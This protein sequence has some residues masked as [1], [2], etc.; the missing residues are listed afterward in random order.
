MPWQDEEISGP[1]GGDIPE[2]DALAGVFCFIPRFDCSV[3]GRFDIEDGNGEYA[4]SSIMHQARFRFWAAR[5]VNRDDDWPLK[6]F[7]G[8]DSDERDRLLFCIRTSL[9]L[10]DLFLPIGTHVS[11]ESAQPAHI[12][13]A[14]RLQKQVEIGDR[15]VRAHPEPLA[16]LGPHVEQTHCVRQ[17]H[18]GRCCT[19]PLG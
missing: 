1:G 16:K 19:R 11:R 10:A 2:P 18:V 7:G 6:T 14:R 13:G 12:I 15:P 8:M 5:H 4:R 3:S 17:Q 9:D